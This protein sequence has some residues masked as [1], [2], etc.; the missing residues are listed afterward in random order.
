MLFDDLFS[1]AKGPGVIGT[2]MALIVLLGFGL[3]FMLA[4]DQ[5]FK[6][7]EKSLA[8]IIRETEKEIEGTR[9]RI[10]SGEDLLQQIPRLEELVSAFNRATA[11]NES[12]A[13][14]VS[15]RNANIQ[16]LKEKR[17][18]KLTEWEDYRNQYR[19]NIRTTAV[20]TSIPELK[21]TE[22][23]IYLAVVISKV[24]AIGIHIRHKDG[25]SNLN[26][27]VLPQEIQDYY[28]YDEKQMLSET[29]RLAEVTQSLN[30]AAATVH[31]AN[32]VA[33]AEQKD[34]DKKA[35][36]EKIIVKIAMME[37]QVSS[38]TGQISQLE[39]D[40][41][42]AQSAASAARAAGRIHLSN[43]G[44]LR[45]QLN[46]KRADLLRVQQG[47]ARLNASL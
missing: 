6:G 30:K 41:V 16:A 18:N 20:G 3:L 47:I 27:K 35:D 39:G 11:R 38:L 44:I 25:L 34:N 33:N 32:E 37:A 46:Q 7:G 15:S 21:T 17:D 42:S 8:S 14:G 24:T 19:A 5:G 4:S 28:Q 22:G 31:A 23:K 40:I 26:F 2:I 43:A 13:A 12:L 10:Q 36:R 45:G 9:S 29:K 1:S